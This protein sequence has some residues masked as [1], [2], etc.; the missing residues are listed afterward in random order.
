MF[1]VTL[2]KFKNK[3]NPEDEYRNA[4]NAIIPYEEFKEPQKRLVGKART[5]KNTIDNLANVG[6]VGKHGESNTPKGSGF[7]GKGKGKA[8]GEKRIKAK[9]TP[10]LTIKKKL[11]VAPVV[12]E[13]AP[14]KIKKVNKIPFST[15]TSTSEINTWQ[16]K[17]LNNRK[18]F[19][20]ACKLF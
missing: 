4:L 2:I 14:I 1:I 15:M 17:T 3:S 20:V 16:V 9:P 10:S 18:I 11:P 6:Q 13:N 8:E 5:V 12:E 19:F 7:E